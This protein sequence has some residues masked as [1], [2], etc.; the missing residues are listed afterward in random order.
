V[1][2]AWAWLGLVGLL[3]A[4]LMALV[5]DSGPELELEPVAE[6]AAPVEVPSPAPEDSS[7]AD[8]APPTE[9]SEAAPSL[10][11]AV[12]RTTAVAKPP[13]WTAARQFLWGT[14]RGTD[15]PLAGARVVLRD[16][17]EEVLGEVESA[18]GGRFQVPLAGPVS[19]ANL[20]VSAPGYAP[21][22]GGPHSVGEDQKR[23]VGT[24][25]LTPG[26]P[27][28]GTL[29]SPAN[30]PVANAEVR[31]RPGGRT[32]GLNRAELKARTDAEGRFRI[33]RA[34]VGPVELNV[35]AP[36]YAALRYGPIDL[37]L[38]QPLVIHMRAGSDLRVRVVQLDGEAIAGARVQLSGRNQTAHH[39]MTDRSGHVS[40]RNLGPEP[41]VITA[42]ADGY[43]M[44][45]EDA[46]APRGQT[47]DVTLLGM[48]CVR[49]RV[50]V[51]DGSAL[52]RGTYVTAHPAD[53][54]GGFRH[55]PA[56][57]RQE[58]DANGGFALCGLVP[59]NYVVRADAEG[60]APSFSRTTAA[61]RDANA[62]AVSVLLDAG[63]QLEV[64]LSGGGLALPGQ[65][66]RLF[67]RAPNESLRWHSASS[68]GKPK[69]SGLVARG[70][71]SEDGRVA[72]E[73]LARGEYWVVA[74]APG[75][76]TAIEG[77]FR[78]QVAG[79][80]LPIVL[81]PG[82]SIHGVVHRG[83]ETIGA[84]GIRVA[85]VPAERFPAHQLIADEKGRYR[86]AD[87]PPGEY[88]LTCSS[89]SFSE[90]Q[91][92]LPVTVR[93]GEDSEADFY[94]AEE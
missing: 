9:R 76:V 33:P 57:Q 31:V 77:P 48:P 34:P 16:A 49:G 69:E 7:V 59:G 45:Q 83:K 41:V 11:P 39:G 67:D 79:K 66:V 20:E 42:S 23:S 80:P 28:E 73:R 40:F 4:G 55:D 3:A 43:Q 68:P 74:E 71:T 58:V 65:S 78:S 90:T 60:Y 94:L 1:K 85:S 29:L 91:A 93:P 25:T 19:R 75:F 51:P 27:F 17:D 8:L 56:A 70:T 37:P 15:G 50:A 10:E 12:E 88:E 32:A 53:A 44:R 92:S 64:S 89:V 18:T 21:F 54:A 61:S 84:A 62:P 81:D 47:V 26:V 36:D 63:Q 2:R 24:V 22:R 13:T 82:A 6:E 87:L 52:P 46:V 72:F 38:V 35:V 30:A 86:T 14:V 5:L